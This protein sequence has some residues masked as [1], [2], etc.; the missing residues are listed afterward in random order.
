MH[1]PPQ[2]PIIHQ[3]GIDA[4]LRFQEA[5]SAMAL[6]SGSTMNLHREFISKIMQGFYVDFMLGK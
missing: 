5:V 4:G 3:G 1:I 2:L 6:S